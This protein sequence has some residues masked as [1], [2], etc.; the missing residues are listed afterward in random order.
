VNGHG[1]SLVDVLVTW[2]N[3]A[4]DLLVPIA[5]R[6]HP[7]GVLPAH[8]LAAR[9][10]AIRQLRWTMIPRET[11]KQRFLWPSM[12][13]HFYADTQRHDG[14]PFTRNGGEVV[15]ELRARK[16]VF[17][18]ELILLRWADDR[19]RD[20]ERQLDALIAHV[21]SYLELQEN[22]LPRISSQLPAA[23]QQRL[24]DRLTARGGLLPVQAHPD[25]PVVPWLAVVLG[26]IAGVADRLRDRFATSPG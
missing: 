5:P 18:Q 13:K 10:D 24:A 9:S 26:P 17:E 25:L 14:V 19:S 3:E 22:L 4:R 23:E 21:R 2:Q 16:V 12:R 11:R 15:E 1:T 6:P 8:E 7:E 20:F